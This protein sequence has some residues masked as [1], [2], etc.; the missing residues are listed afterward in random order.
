MNIYE[1]IDEVKELSKQSPHLITPASP[2]YL[3]YILIRQ[4]EIIIEL[5]SSVLET[6]GNTEKQQPAKVAGRKSNLEQL[7]KEEGILK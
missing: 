3:T 1:K 4:N 5:L 2:H 6:N 7:L